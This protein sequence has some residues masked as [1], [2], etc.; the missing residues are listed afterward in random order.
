[1]NVWTVKCNYKRRDGGQGWHWKRYLAE[2]GQCFDFGGPEWIRSKAS[3]RHIRDGVTKGDLVL[4][5]QTDEKAILA[6]TRMASNG[7]EHSATPGEFN[8]FNLV[9]AQQ[10]LGFEP[11]VTI[12]EL[13]Q[14]GCD[15]ACFRTGTQ[16]TVFP[17]KSDDWTAILRT[18]KAIRPSLGA[19]LKQWFDGSKMTR[20]AGHGTNK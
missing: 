1:M 14:N 5:Y 6:L 17:V 13:R 9:S 11:P 19:R 12:A 10:T 16:G 20:Q 15:P 4:C 8:M 2:T 7:Y 3:Q 18:I